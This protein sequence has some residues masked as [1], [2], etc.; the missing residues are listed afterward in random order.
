[1][2]LNDLKAL[3]R[4]YRIS[5]ELQDHICE[6]VNSAHMTDL[7]EDSQKETVDPDTMVPDMGHNEIEMGWVQTQ[8][9][10]THNTE[11]QIDQ[12]GPY[13]NL[14]V[15][16]I[17]GM[18]EVLRVRDPKLNRIIALKVI[19]AE[20]LSKGLR[21]ARF[22]EEA[23][24][25]AQLQHPNIVP[26]HE[27]GELD[28]GRLYFTM[29]EVK[30]LPF[31][32]AIQEVHA[33]SQNNRWQTAASGWNFRR[34]IDAFT[35]A[36]Q[37][38]AYAHS[39]GVLH[40]DLKPANI[41]LGE[42][43]EVLVVDWGIAKVLG[44]AHTEAEIEFVET[45]RVRLGIFSTMSGQVAGTPAYMAP[46]QARGEIDQLDERTDIYALGA[47][48]Y[49]ILTGRPPYVG[50]SGLHVLQQVLSGPPQSI[51]ESYTS[52]SI[53]TFNFQS[54]DELLSVKEGLPLPDVLVEACQRAMSRDKIHRFRSVVEFTK[55]LSDWL[56][57]SKKRDEALNVV[58]SALSLTQQMRNL[59]SQAAQLAAEAVAGL[60]KISKYEDESI[61]APWWAKEQESRELAQRAQALDVLQE[62]QLQGALT[63]TA[64]LEE[65]HVA[66][67]KR[68]RQKHEEAEQSSDIEAAQQAEMRLREHAGALPEGHNER[69]NHFAYLKGVGA[70]TITSEMAKKITI[71]RYVQHYR[72]LALMPVASFT[73]SQL[74]G[75]ALEMGS[76]LIRIQKDGYHDSLYPIF[77]GRG[78]HWS[79]RNPEGKLQPVRCI[80]AGILSDDEAF[81]PAGYF[82]AGGDDFAN[83]S[84]DRQRIWVN[85]FVM[86]KFP[87]T[88]RQY[89]AFL[90]ELVNNGQE[91][92]A[93][94][95]VPRERTS[96]NG[97]LGSM[98]YGQK[99]NGHFQLIPDAD[100]DLWQ[101]D[102][103]V[104]MVNWA[105]AQ[106]YAKWL[107]LK[108]GLNWRLPT[109][110]EWEKAA[111]GVD[112]RY[113]SWGNH[114]DASYCAMSYSHKG[115]Q[116]PVVVG[117]FQLD[118]SPYNIF[119]M[120]G[121]VRDWTASN[122]ELD[123]HSD[124]Q[125]VVRGGCW[126]STPVYTRL[127]RRV[128]QR[129]H[130]RT[131]DVGFRWVRDI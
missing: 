14:G 28:D 44:Y 65:A 47:I 52:Q 87:V 97:Q 32:A 117:Q 31:G 13:D 108:T 33:A 62:Q 45:E 116:T 81:I 36:C 19:Y 102:W 70:L 40:R 41:M 37:A 119:G 84:F 99:S 21:Y 12:I 2:L 86:S 9:W 112:G 96:Q 95:W 73:S 128:P 60:Q 11:K 109:E 79:S 120:S 24:V 50:S 100:G 68:Y 94:K 46:E 26:V 7:N 124:D 39:K 82:W 42:Y 51:R 115:R 129:Q 35:K 38:M 8:G 101:L 5:K 130:N 78:E 110:I 92:D 76:Y 43:D 3:L 20:S 75:H 122:W 113:F 121:N 22:I 59:E 1:M 49:E 80:P 56:D 23:Q 90:N 63:H 114:F 67:A 107:A 123:G 85:D 89:I 48:L 98:I 58:E 91:E 131:P 54:I 6:L 77:I 25:V 83:G 27:I 61:K 17:G 126:F 88:N 111:R 74:V 105:C 18:G 34:L 104:L 57:G 72:R 30:G 125:K 71:E 10:P 127:A 15:L 29:K 106:A 103:P 93:L 118:R 64:D 66:L 4:Q 55:V 16:G 69:T 53:K